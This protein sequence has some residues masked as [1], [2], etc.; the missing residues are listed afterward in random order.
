MRLWL[1][2]TLEAILARLHQLLGVV[3][4]RAAADIDILMPGYTHLQVRVASARR[5]EGRRARV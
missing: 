2:D 1:R 4:A 3:T 5:R